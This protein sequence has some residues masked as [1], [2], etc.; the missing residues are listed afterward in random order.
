VQEKA[1]RASGASSLEEFSSDAVR[2]PQGEHM[3]VW[4]QRLASSGQ[5]YVGFARL[6]LTRLRLP[7][8]GLAPSRSSP[9]RIRN[10]RASSAIVRRGG[11]AL[12]SWPNSL[13]VLRLRKCNLVH[14]GQ[15]IPSYSC[16]HTSSLVRVFVRPML[17]VHRCRRAPENEIGHQYNMA[18]QWHQA[19]I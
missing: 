16:S 11:Y 2:A 15:M 19:M 13:P 4:P 10:S 17:D 5:C 14:A 6:P 7:R 9:R 8:K 12:P 18:A 3:S 1:P